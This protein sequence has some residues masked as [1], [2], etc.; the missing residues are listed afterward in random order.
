MPSI[1]NPEV[2]S[3]P[4]TTRREAARLLSY[5]GVHLNRWASN[6]A[7]IDRSIAR[8]QKRIT[9]LQEQKKQV[10][11]LELQPA[12]E[13]AALLADYA[14]TGWDALVEKGTR[15]IRFATGEVRMRDVPRPRIVLTQGKSAFL[16]EARRKNR[17]RALIRKVEEPNLDAIQ[18]DLTLAEG[19]RSVEIVYDQKVELR[20][21]RSGD[22][23]LEGSHA[24]DAYEIEW[25]IARPKAQRTLKD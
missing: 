14:L 15:T 7:R 17:A 4:P 2:P 25:D 24:P 11:H 12:R 16:T 9:Q 5:I 19:M 10:S 6:E 20:P 22:L 18:K 3:A 1:P 23:R 8:Y 13:I 21:N